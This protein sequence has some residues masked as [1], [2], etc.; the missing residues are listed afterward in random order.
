MHKGQHLL[1]PS[2]LCQTCFLCDTVLGH[3]LLRPR[4]LYMGAVRPVRGPKVLA[5]MPFSGQSGHV[6]GLMPAKAS[7]CIDFADLTLDFEPQAQ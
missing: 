3:F 7:H 4:T 6:M 1:C 2:S 5:T